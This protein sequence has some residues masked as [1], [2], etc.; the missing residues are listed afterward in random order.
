MIG[1]VLFAFIL[2]ETTKLIDLVKTILLQNNI[3]LITIA[4]T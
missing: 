4:R 2:K 1:S 3:K